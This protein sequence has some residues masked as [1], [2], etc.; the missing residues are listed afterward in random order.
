MGNIRSYNSVEAMLEDLAKAERDA[1]FNILPRQEGARRDRNKHWLVLVVQGEDPIW[2]YGYE[3]EEEDEFRFN[4][5]FGK[6]HSAVLPEGE[7][8]SHHLSACLPIT[9]EE[10]A[11][12]EADGWLP[13]PGVVVR[14]AFIQRDQIWKIRGLSIPDQG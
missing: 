3:E 4:R 9:K 5:V 11:R 13:D 7:Y 6:W 10:Y 12:A 1:D 8:G 14:M 2:I